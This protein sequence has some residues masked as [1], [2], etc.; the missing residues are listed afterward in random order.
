MQARGWGFTRR[1]AGRPADRL[2]LIAGGDAC[3]VM[4]KMLG[5]G[6]GDPSSPFTPGFEF[7]GVLVGG[8]TCALFFILAQPK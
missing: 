2:M 1:D 4:A 6:G 7:A 3:W 5:A 8:L